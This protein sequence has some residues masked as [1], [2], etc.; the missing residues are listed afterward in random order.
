M[1]TPVLTSSSSDRYLTYPLLEMAGNDRILFLG[2]YLYLYD[3]SGNSAPPCYL[4]HQQ[5][6]EQKARAQT[7]L[8]PLPSLDSSPTRIQNYQIP[9]TVL[10]VLDYVTRSY[11]RCALEYGL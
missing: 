10:E 8:N 11:D 2:H 5:Y 9:Q 4:Q 3:K 6:D 7:P 1:A